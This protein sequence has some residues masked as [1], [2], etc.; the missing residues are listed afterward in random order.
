MNKRI[1]ITLLILCLATSITAQGKYKTKTASITFEASV[2]S[3]EEVKGTNENVSAILNTDTGEFASLA[4]V[5]GFRFKVALMEEHFNENYLE[6]TVFPKAIF[7][8]KLDG[9]LMSDVSEEISEY[10]L[11]GSITI[12]GVTQPLEAQVKVKI[13]NDVIEL[14]TEFILKPEQF[15]IKIPK[16]VSNKIAEEVFVLAMYSLSN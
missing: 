14:A 8:G 10:T 6:S 1:F 3:Y 15:N 5:T 7:K 4:L 2:P 9:F 13:V 11:K 12:H 16:I